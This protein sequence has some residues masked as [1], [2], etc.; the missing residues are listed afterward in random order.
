[1]TT[2]LDLARDASFR[3]QA[4]WTE[5]LEWMHEPQRAAVLHARRVIAV[6]HHWIDLTLKGDAEARR[7]LAEGKR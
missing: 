4:K 7:R 2:D 1:M 5:T 6:T 3:V